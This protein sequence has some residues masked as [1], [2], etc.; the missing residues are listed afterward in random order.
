MLKAIVLPSVRRGVERS[1][2]AFA[3]QPGGRVVEVPAD[4]DALP[5]PRQRRQ[6]RPRMIR[7]RRSCL[8]LKPKPSHLRQ[9]PS[10]L[11]AQSA[12]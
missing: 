3:V 6:F 9:A 5:V 10:G 12:A 11:T 2:G 4:P 8:T 1:A 7:P